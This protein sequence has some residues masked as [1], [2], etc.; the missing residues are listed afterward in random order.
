MTNTTHR[1]S[2]TPMLRAHWPLFVILAAA[3]A[4]Y[5]MLLPGQVFGLRNDDAQYVMLARA[6]AS[7]RG[8]VDS[9]LPGNPISTFVPPG[10][11]ALLVPLIWFFPGSVLA[12]E[13]SSVVFS[14]IAVVLTYIYLRLKALPAWMTLLVTVLFA[15]NP[16]VGYY[17]GIAMA[18]APF[19]GC[20]MALLI[21]L[22]F[23]ERTDRPLNGWAILSV[24]LAAGIFYL[25]AAGVLIPFAVIA[26]FFLIRKPR[27]ALTLAVGI[28]L[29][30]G[31]F[32]VGRMMING[33]LVG[34]GYEG[35]FA[36]AYQGNFASR[37][38]RV[39][40]TMLNGIWQY[41]TYAFSITLVPTVPQVSILNTP[42]VLALNGF[43]A[44]IVGP[45]VL[46]GWLVNSAR[47]RDA[48]MLIAPA[49]FGMTLLWPYIHE[50]RVILL[51]P[52][53]ILYFVVGM[54][55]VIVEALPRVVRFVPA[56][57]ARGLFAI[58]LML[59]IAVHVARFVVDY[60]L[61][62]VTPPPVLQI[63]QDSPWVEFLTRTTGSDDVFATN[64]W[65]RYHLLTGRHTV[66][67]FW[68]STCMEIKFAGNHDAFWRDVGLYKP[69]FILL[70]A[71][72][73]DV[74]EYGQQDHFCLLSILD[75]YPDHFVRV[76]SQ[77]P[78]KIAIY[79]VLSTDPEDFARTNLTARAAPQSNSPD[80][81]MLN[82][83][84]RA[85]PTNYILYPHNG[86]AELTIPLSSAALI[87]TIT[88]GQAGSGTGRVSRLQ[89]MLQA[90]S[91]EWRNVDTLENIRIGNAEA[92]AIEPATQP[93]Y[94]RR[95][96]QPTPAN[97]IRVRFE[98]EGWFYASDF[99]AI[100]L[101]TPNDAPR[102]ELKDP[103]VRA[104]GKGDMLPVVWQSA[105]NSPAQIGVLAGESIL[106]PATEQT[107]F[108]LEA[109][110]LPMNDPDRPIPVVGDWDGTGVQS[111]GVF[112]RGVFQLRTRE[113]WRTIAF[114]QPG[115]RPVV[116]DWNGDGVTTFGIYRDGVF[117][118]TDNFDG[119]MPN[120]EQFIRTPLENDPK[121]LN[122]T[123]FAGDWDGDGKDSLGVYFDSQLAMW[124]K[125]GTAM[126]D[127]VVQFG[128]PGDVP[129]VG[130][131]NGDGKTEIAVFRFTSI[132]FGDLTGR[133]YAVQPHVSIAH[134]VRL[135]PAP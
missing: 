10:Y 51:L 84:P 113:G 106:M 100:G 54:Y 112:R 126:P 117:Y 133:T 26:Y 90:P 53:V 34:Y 87:D 5:L 47:R 74:N 122:L 16:V 63:E 125:I 103:L 120:Y 80:S 116:G 101:S 14:L 131:W 98:G 135:P 105:P 42:P 129:I 19:V 91:G 75:S 3:L 35:T 102:P 81:V 62:Y 15:L 78:S 57:V 107:A 21:A 2:F 23:Y 61:T 68:P 25:K 28:G 110:I 111:P 39:L 9:A 124:N 83:A 31:L 41:M 119:G 13:L 27:H 36:G 17:S 104:V 55:A 108:S 69:R 127:Q 70:Q 92:G 132:Y 49:Y 72:T 32:V 7:G 37:V 38:T 118:L 29:L 67:S 44:F 94:Y 12:L 109:K 79:E 40:L 52:L 66:G 8:F 59:V 114:G 6:L 46:A 86:A 99:N 76:Y 60:Q 24:L 4:Y 71:D 82:T 33:T 95:L 123:P 56:L 18:E 85:V 115:D 77:T 20:L 22:H 1:P 45:L 58:V 93:Y 50:R 96:P 88:L 65:Y 73:Y 30:L 43:F 89:V 134:A 128:I 64:V 11:P 48:A 130:D 121:D 97:A